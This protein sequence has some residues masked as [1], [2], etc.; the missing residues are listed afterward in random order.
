MHC[1]H[2]VIKW[3]FL[4]WI[5]ILCSMF[6]NFNC[7]LYRQNIEEWT[8]DLR[9][10]SITWALSQVLT[11]IG[12]PALTLTWTLIGHPAMSP[13]NTSPEP[14]TWTPT[15]LLSQDTDTAQTL[16]ASSCLSFLHTTSQPPHLETDSL[17]LLQFSTHKFPA[18]SPGLSQSQSFIR[19]CI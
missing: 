2:F 18:S 17:L 16:T 3:M 14:T 8:P 10:L 13:R 19:L 4:L 7:Q 11:L 5:V 6:L 15:S 1:Q 12:Q 9:C